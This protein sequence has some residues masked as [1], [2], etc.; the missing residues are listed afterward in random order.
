MTVLELK[1]DTVEMIAKV[2]DKPTMIRLHRMIADFLE[3][4]LGESNGWDEL[5]PAQQKELDI[6]IAETEDENKWVSHEA[7]LKK[8]EKWTG[9]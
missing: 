7:V 1:G 8:F 5:S 9:N 4:H 2:Q 3:L 6:A